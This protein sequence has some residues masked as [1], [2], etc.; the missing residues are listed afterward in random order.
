MRYPCA[1][2]L[3][4]L[5]MDPAST[6]KYDS[7]K[8]DDPALSD[9]VGKIIRVVVAICFRR[10]VCVRGP[11]RAF[12]AGPRRETRVS[13]TLPSPVVLRGSEVAL[14]GLPRSNAVTKFYRVNALSLGVRDAR[15]ADALTYC[16]VSMP[17]RSPAA[18]WRVPD[19]VPSYTPVRAGRDAT[20]ASPLL[21]HPDAFVPE[22]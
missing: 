17:V 19:Y 18:L 16:R 20:F 4:R 14:S 15:A 1:T 3:I 12:P 8:R 5:W 7:P 10:W 22:P 6:R 11:R 2:H 13:S 21:I 9:P